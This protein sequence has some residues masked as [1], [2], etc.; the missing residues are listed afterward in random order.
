MLLNNHAK[1]W[2]WRDSWRKWM[3]NL[4]K[5][6]LSLNHKLQQL[7]NLRNPFLWWSV[8]LKN[9]KAIIDLWARG[10]KA[11]TQIMPL[12]RH[13][14]SCDF[15]L[16]IVSLKSTFTQNNKNSSQKLSL[17]GFWG[18]GVLGFLSCSLFLFFLFH[19]DFLGFLVF[20]FINIILGAIILR[21]WEVKGSHVFVII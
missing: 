10:V 15:K 13:K 20:F 7:S 11:A 17:K 6:N 16:I 21:L 2:S 19:W 4:S 3:S 5:I 8:W 18:F 14:S 12:K 9:D 1:K